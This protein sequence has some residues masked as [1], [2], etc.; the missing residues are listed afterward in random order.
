MPLATGMKPFGIG[1]RVRIV[2]PFQQAENCEGTS[3]AGLTATV[4]ATGHLKGQSDF[5]LCVVEFDDDT[6][7]GVGKL[8]TPKPCSHKPW[9]QV[10]QVMEVSEKA[11]GIHPDRRSY[12]VVSNANVVLLSDEP[13]P[14]NNDGRKNCFW[15]GSP[16]EKIQGFRNNY[17]FCRSCK[18]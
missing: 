13:E 4:V 11:D 10:S 6:V 8:P 2:G 14:E 7:C 12:K 15:C 3:F 1:S 9:A 5:N 17:D 16:T 18:K